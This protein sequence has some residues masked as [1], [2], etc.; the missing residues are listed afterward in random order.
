MNRH[1]VCETTTYLTR[2]VKKWVKLIHFDRPQHTVPHSNS[3]LR[4]VGS[5]ALRSRFYSA[6][7]YFASTTPSLHNCSHHMLCY[8]LHSTFDLRNRGYECLP[9]DS[10][11]AQQH[12]QRLGISASTFTMWL[13]LHR[14]LKRQNLASEN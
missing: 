14:W 1:L 8:T 4:C 3:K 6:M 13:I 7:Q 9:A 5:K 2:V 11:S 10:G 12:E